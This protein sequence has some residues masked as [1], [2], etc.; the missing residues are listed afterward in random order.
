MANEVAVLMV[1]YEPPIMMTCADGTAIPKG[2][3][4]KLSDPY[5]VAATS[6]DNDVFGGIAAE[7]KII[8]DG[9]T[10]IAVYRR[11][12][13]KVTCGTGGSTVGKEQVIQALNQV[14]DYTT[15]DGEKGY[16]FGRA[17]ETATAGEFFLMELGV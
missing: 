3:L 7:D 6:A 13:F 16:V 14:T 10:K 2:T 11:G 4:L 17:L 9:K 5:T 1:E 12:I 15:L 8:S